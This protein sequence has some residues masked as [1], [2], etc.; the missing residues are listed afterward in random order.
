MPV[1]LTPCSFKLI[2]QYE[3]SIKKRVDV[4]ALREA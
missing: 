2:F 3:K 1:Q 4:S